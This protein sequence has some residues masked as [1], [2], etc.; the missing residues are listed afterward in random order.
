M[1]AKAIEL[2]YS[3]THKDETLRKKLDTHLSML[4]R[5]GLINQWHDRKISAGS[6][7]AEEID[8]HL[9]SA[10]IILLLVSPAFIASDYCY[11][12]MQK[13]IIRQVAGESRAIPIILRPCDW[14]SAPFG[15]LHALPKNAKPVTMWSNRDAAFTDI[16]KGIRHVINELNGNT[17]ITASQAT[18]TQKRNTKTGKSNGGRKIQAPLQPSAQVYSRNQ[19]IATTKNLTS[20]K[21]KQIMSLHLD[22][23]F[24]IYSQIQHGKSNGH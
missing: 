17:P 12:Q 22:Q 2:F 10:N 16:A 21:G 14:E 19:L 5:E 1:M 7:W 20:T 15:K 4:K 8:A 13:A 24:K 9:K 6:L 3:Y 23:L 18:T 11:G